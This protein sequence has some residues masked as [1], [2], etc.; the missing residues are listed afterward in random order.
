MTEEKHAGIIF[1]TIAGTV[2]IHFSI[3]ISY[4][5]DAYQSVASMKSL[6]WTNMKLAFLFAGLM[7]VEVF[8]YKKLRNKLKVE[9]WED[10]RLFALSIIGTFFISMV[11]SMGIW[12]IIFYG[13]I[14]R[15]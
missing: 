10:K 15:I 1:F 12:S 13:M 3:M 9:D 6:M 2:V 11:F 4:L 8:F 7:K 14:K 5:I